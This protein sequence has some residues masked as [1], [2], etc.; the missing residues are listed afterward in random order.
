MLEDIRVAAD[1]GADGI[2]TGCLDEQGRIDHYTL[3]RLI[4]ASG[5]LPVTFHKAID[6]AQDKL[7]A[8]RVLRDS[9]CRRVL[10]SGGQASAV[11]G[12]SLMSEMIGVLGPGA[13]LMPGGGLQPGHIPVLYDA[14]GVIEFHG[15][16]RSRSGPE[17]A[18]NPDPSLVAEARRLL[19]GLSA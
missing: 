11:D 18:V 10:S 16:F 15:A 1:L 9:G 12:L 3:E 5:N 13:T 2:V 7:E 19:D 6:V 17:E 8:C 4:A 14:L